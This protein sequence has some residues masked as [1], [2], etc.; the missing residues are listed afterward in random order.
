MIQEGGKCPVCGSRRL[1]YG[2]SGLVEGSY[3]FDWRCLDCQSVGR[4]YSDLIFSQH[5]IYSRG[6]HTLKQEYIDALDVQ[7]WYLSGYTNDGRVKIGKYSPAGELV[8]ICA[9][10]MGLSCDV[11]EC[12]EE[13]DPDR[14]VKMLIESGYRAEN[15]APQTVRGLLED[16][17][18][19]KRMLR[20]LADALEEV[21]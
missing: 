18:D 14:H 19:I 5:E 6:E 12:A 13:F 15:G 11:S 3:F 9:E 10:V 8:S 7:G 4:E 16:A 2:A 20:E 17:E 1:A 21:G